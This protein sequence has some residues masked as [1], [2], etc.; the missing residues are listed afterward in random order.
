MVEPA[1]AT[2]IESVLLELLL[3]DVPVFVESFDLDLSLLSKSVG[4]AFE[5]CLFS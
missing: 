2:L 4:G 5:P 3:L 1:I